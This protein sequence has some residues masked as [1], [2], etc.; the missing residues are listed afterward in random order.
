M[1]KTLLIGLAAG[2]VFCIGCARELNKITQTSTIDALLAG[3]YDGDMSCEELL[4]FGDFGIGTFDT[5][6]GEMVI[7]DGMVYQIRADGKVYRP[8]LKTK[9]P[10]ATVCNFEPDMSFSMRSADYHGVKSI[11]DEKM[12]NE[13]IFVAIEISG[14]FK[15][16]KA[17]SVPAQQKPYP[18]LA[19]VAKNQ[20]IFEMTDVEGTVI[21]FRSPGFVKGINV[22]GYH[23]HFLSGDKTKGGHVLD[24]ELDEA[25]FKGD[26]CNKF[27]LVL[28]EDDKLKDLDLS[29][30]KSEEL[31]KVEMGK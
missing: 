31:E 22:S 14:S 12:P 21:G 8:G 5:L 25:V 26:I 28:P 11:I 24:I 20:P 23:F 2:I 6:D 9:T 3:A 15:Y 27:L 19:E 1:R 18:P 10:F 7:Y 29:I 4:K 16:V 30:D 17:R 13:N